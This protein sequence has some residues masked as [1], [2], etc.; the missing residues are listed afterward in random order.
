MMPD[1]PSIIMSTLGLHDAMSGID[2]L[3]NI[4]HVSSCPTTQL[5]DQLRTEG[6]Q[7][8]F[9]HL[10]AGMKFVSFLTPDMESENDARHGSV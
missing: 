5:R 8:E 4:H 1:M 7:A 3:T 2:K 10:I 6:L 9:G